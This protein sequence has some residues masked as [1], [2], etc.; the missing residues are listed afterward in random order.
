[1]TSTAHSFL[2]YRVLKSAQIYRCPSGPGSPGPRGVDVQS[3]F[4]LPAPPSDTK[5]GFQVAKSGALESSGPS[6]TKSGFQVA[7]SG[8]LESPSDTKSGFQVANLVCG[9]LPTRN[10]NFKSHI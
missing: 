5:S 8:A 10:L 2:V 1:M 9:P 4:D 3:S 7:K 6:D